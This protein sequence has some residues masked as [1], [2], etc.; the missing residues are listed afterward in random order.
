MGGGGGLA[1]IDA[2]FAVCTSVVLDEGVSISTRG[3]AVSITPVTVGTLFTV[4]EAI[5][6]GLEAPQVGGG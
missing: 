2:V 3:F 5:T 6:V 1:G 4:L